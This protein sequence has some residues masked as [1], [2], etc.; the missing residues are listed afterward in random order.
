M[1]ADHEVAHALNAAG[2]HV[3]GVEFDRPLYRIQRGLVAALHRLQIG[4]DG[5][6]E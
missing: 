3:V 5:E 6:R 4:Q 2:A 1:L